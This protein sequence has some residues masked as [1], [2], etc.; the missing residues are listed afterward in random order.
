MI[1]QL[2]ELVWKVNRDARQWIRRWLTAAEGQ[3]KEA[4]IGNNS[5][6]QVAEVQ[7]ES[8]LRRA[9]ERLA[10]GEVDEVQETLKY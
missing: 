4:E 6:R 1:L 8:P 10:S 7:G 2:E 5:L 3:G 9:T